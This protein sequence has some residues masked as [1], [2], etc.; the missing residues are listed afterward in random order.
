MA[1]LQSPL[2]QVLLWV[3]A[4]AAAVWL[5]TPAVM[6]ALGKGRYWMNVSDNPT[7]AEPDGRDRKYDSRYREFIALGFRPAGKIVEHARFKLSQWNWESGGARYLVSP[8]GKTFVSFF[9]IAGGNPLRMNACS[10]FEEGGLIQTAAPG[11][12]INRDLGPNYKYDAVGEA[13][14]EELLGMHA[15]R[16]EAFVRDRDLTVKA[17]TMRE[18][19]AA[20][21]EFTRRVTSNLTSGSGFGMLGVFF[22]PLAMVLFSGR[23]L[24][25]WMRPLAVCAAL[26]FM[27]LFR[28]AILPNRIP[29]MI[30]MGIM[31]GVVMILPT[32]MP[33][34]LM[35][36]TRITN[37]ILDRFEADGATAQPARV[38]DRIVRTGPSA[39]TA[40]LKRLENPATRSETRA[41]IHDALVKLR[42]S[43]LGEA[44]T[45]WQGWC[46]D[47]RHQR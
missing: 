15:R 11:V 29:R 43:D 10:I 40:L 32:A 1:I 16:L 13:E 22:V 44:P 39:C 2:V 24:S 35:S 37:R 9:R 47:I 30:R 20:V 19:A 12:A 21:E 38:V 4:A 31:L 46:A 6:G 23:G 8:D 28:W 14:P 45:A 18:I 34:W 3:I 17:A 25:G 41:I 26:A 36:P 42:G 7:D 33:L 27:A 5:L